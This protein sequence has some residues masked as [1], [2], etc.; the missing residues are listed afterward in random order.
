IVSLGEVKPSAEQIDRAK[1][2]QLPSTFFLYENKEPCKGCPGCE[3][4][5]PSIVPDESMFF[6]LLPIIITR[7]T[8]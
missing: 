8:N 2:L 3:Q 1:K 4:D 7:H 5:T 6:V